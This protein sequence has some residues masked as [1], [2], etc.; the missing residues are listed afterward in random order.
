[1]RC[2]SSGAEKPGAEE[3][4]RVAHLTWS[5]DS[6]Q[7]AFAG[8]TAEGWRIVCGDKRS[9]PFDEVGPPHFSADG[10]KIAFGARKGRELWWKVL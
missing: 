2:D 6:K 7:L 1:M 4:R 8:E 9:E 10:A 5:Q 3:F